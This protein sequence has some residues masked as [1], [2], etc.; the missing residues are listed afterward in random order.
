MKLATLLASVLAATALT[1]AAGN[2]SFTYQGALRD[3]SGAPLAGNKTVEFR[4]YTQ[5]TGG[6]AAWG[7]TCNVL[8]DTNGLFNTEIS[9]TAGTAIAGI[10]N[11]SLD[12]F[13][14]QNA[15]SPVY[16]GVT[17]AD[18]A[19][20]IAPRQRL[21]PVPYAVFAH[22]VATASGD[23]EASGRVTAKALSVSGASELKGSA[24]V[25]GD[26][27]VEGKLKVSGTLSGYGVIPVGGIIIWSGAA[28]KIP[29]GWHLCDGSSGTPDLRSRFV[30]G[31]GG[32]YSVGSKGGAESVTLG[33]DQIPAHDHLYSGDDHIDYINGYGY[34]TS[35]HVVGRP[36]GYDASSSG[37]GD[38]TVYTTSS[39]GGGK[40]HENRPP[41]YA[42]CYIMRTK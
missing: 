34:K 41:Y 1:A 38:G 17:V 23:F 10:A 24:S 7:K 30:V 11:D 16:I 20:E 31:A 19:G 37:S 42:L 25:A 4:L 27:S 22:D 39:T 3:S 40:S 9:D 12:S 8:L 14:T 6:T 2:A 29:D 13:F 21:L 15:N 35:D 33:V 28:N 36:G 26:V 5:A 18:T 32:S